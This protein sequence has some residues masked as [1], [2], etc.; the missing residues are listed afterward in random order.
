MLRKM[1]ST[2]IALFIMNSLVAC[3][4]QN[5][6]SQMCK[7]RIKSLQTAANPHKNPTLTTQN[8]Y[9][10]TP[11]MIRS[12][13]LNNNIED[14]F[15]LLAALR[16][17]NPTFVQSGQNILHYLT[18]H[19]LLN[20]AEYLLKTQKKFCEGQI[21]SRDDIFVAKVLTDVNGKDIYGQT[22]L[23]YARILQNEAFLQ[24]LLNYEFQL[25]LTDY[26]QATIDAMDT[27]DLNSIKTTESNV[28]AAQCSVFQ[29][30]RVKDHSY[31]ALLRGPTENIIQA[32]HTKQI[33][34]SYIDEQ[35]KSLLHDL[36]IAGNT[37]LEKI[38]FLINEGTPMNQQDNQGMTALHYAALYKRYSGAQHLASMGADKSI[39]D[40]LNRTALNIATDNGKKKGIWPNELR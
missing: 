6:S 19:N 22:P 39:K 1:F 27:T 28:G 31:L 5:Y 2:A 38:A 35:G 14:F 23:D 40:N 30:L 21:L 3:Q 7:I 12:L 10:V 32:I 33:D 25:N 26:T 18:Q 15:N 17:N 4:S 11:D 37:R 20:E 29:G 9:L 34:P 8:D 24:L 36:M 13:F 16:T